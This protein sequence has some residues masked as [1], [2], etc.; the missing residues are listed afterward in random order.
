[1]PLAG[2]GPRARGRRAAAGPSAARAREPVWARGRLMKRRRDEDSV[3]EESARCTGRYGRQQRLPCLGDEAK[4][5]NMLEYLT[6]PYARGGV[7]AGA[8]STVPVP[9]RAE[10][11]LGS[12]N[13]LD[14]LKAAASTGR[15]GGGDEL[16]VGWGAS[17]RANEEAGQQHEAA[18]YEGQVRQPTLHQLQLHQDPLHNRPQLQMPQQ[19]GI[20]PQSSL[21]HSRDPDSWNETSGARRDEVSNKTRGDVRKRVDDP[22]SR[23]WSQREL[24]SLAVL[25]CQD[26]PGNWGDKA[27]LL[28]TQRTAASTGSAWRRY[29]RQVK[30]GT[31]EP[32]ANMPSLARDSPSAR[33]GST[34]SYKEVV[35]SGASTSNVGPGSNPGGSGVL[36]RYFLSK[37]A[38]QRLC[39]VWP[40]PAFVQLMFDTPGPTGIS[41]CCCAIKPRGTADGSPKPAEKKQEQ[42]QMEEQRQ[43]CDGKYK[44]EQ[45]ETVF[46]GRVGHPNTVNQTDFDLVGKT[47][48]LRRHLPQRPLSVL[49]KACDID[50][51]S[52]KFVAVIQSVESG[53]AA[54]TLVSR[55][56]VADRALLLREGVD[57]CLEAINGQC[58]HDMHQSYTATLRSLRLQRRPLIILLRTHA[59]G[60]EP[61]ILSKLSQLPIPILQQLQPQITEHGQSCDELS[62]GVIIGDRCRVSIDAPE[63]AKSRPETSQTKVPK[64]TGEAAPGPV[65][66]PT[67]GAAVAMGAYTADEQKTESLVEDADGDVIEEDSSL[68]RRQKQGRGRLQRSYSGCTTTDDEDYE[69]LTD[70][71]S[72]ADSSDWSPL[73]TSSF[74]SMVDEWLLEE[75]KI[76]STSQ[77]SAL[78]S[79]IV[80]D[81][82]GKSWPTEWEACIQIHTEGNTDGHGDS[83]C[84]KMTDDED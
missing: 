78:P 83:V 51:C 22:V 26:G 19:N 63:I 54:D 9:K 60:T 56:P 16:A 25:V 74:P 76:G 70:D 42:A 30:N 10:Q 39:R 5:V 31:R 35:A 12:A 62:R 49:Q 55:L 1:M 48:V 21:D 46:D 33:M 53:S 84:D 69:Y 15:G 14:M 29:E 34:S 44:K 36:A 41:W 73:S 8:T 20:P 71:G 43:E 72:F 67:A 82:I 64:P 66:A 28:G 18:L 24:E 47:E 81:R 17:M 37:E 57:V 50:D 11:V 77:F 32:F 2:C 58:V 40:V 23:P 3:E 79:V 45:Q 38:H 80:N 13:V 61:H 59:I 6:V 52:G 7:R 65:S 27:M 4:Q 75:E 68:E